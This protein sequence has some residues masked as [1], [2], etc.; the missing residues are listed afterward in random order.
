MS[1]IGG[2]PLADD[3]ASNAL[4]T[5]GAIAIPL[6]AR[7]GLTVLQRGRCSI[8]SMELN[9]ETRGAFDGTVHGGMLAT[10]ADVTCALTTWGNYDTDGEVPVTTDLHVRFF[11]QPRSGPLTAEAQ[12]VHAGRRTLASECAIV[13][14]EGRELAR[15]TATF[16]VVART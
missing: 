8:V 4:I 1:R 5:Q 11:R 16:M 3:P 2:T 13:D 14:G 10:L 6:H 12:L 15:A 9:D 7:M